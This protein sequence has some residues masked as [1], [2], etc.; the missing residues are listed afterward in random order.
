M[1]TQ[2]ALPCWDSQGGTN[3]G[4]IEVVVFVMAVAG[5]AAIAGL[6]CVDCV[7]MRLRVIR[8]M[9]QSGKV[10]GKRK[11][12]QGEEDKMRLEKSAQHC[13]VIPLI[14]IPAGP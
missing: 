7:D 14:H 4:M 6:K 5:V 2:K 11:G 9:K 1:G 8:L 12:N 3:E 13:L 10:D